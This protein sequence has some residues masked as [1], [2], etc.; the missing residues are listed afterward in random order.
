[1][2]WKSKNAKKRFFQELR[3]L[4]AGYL[5][6][7]DSAVLPILTPFT[8]VNHAAGFLQDAA[9]RA[10]AGH[11]DRCPR[12]IRCSVALQDNAQQDAVLS[13]FAGQCPRRIL[14]SVTWLD[15]VHAG[16]SDPYPRI[17]LLCNACLVP[18]IHALLYYFK[19][20][21]AETQSAAVIPIPAPH[22]AF[23]RRFRRS[24]KS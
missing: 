4:P 13:G 17:A 2:N 24:G 16:C 7:P 14:Y 3:R 18:L 21:P 8:P 1:M 6:L 15:N 12:R 23:L 22:R 10:A 11:R 9:I 5:F 19:G 20:I